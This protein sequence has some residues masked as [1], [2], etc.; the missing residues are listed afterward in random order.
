MDFKEKIKSSGLKKQ[1]IAEKLGITKEHLSRV[2]NQKSKMTIE[3]EY[4]L[5]NILR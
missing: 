1:K 2:L 3:M 4:R 5:N